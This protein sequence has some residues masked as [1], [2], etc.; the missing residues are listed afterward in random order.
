[1]SRN[2]DNRS[3]RTLYNKSYSNLS[4]RKLRYSTF[5]H[6]R[7]VRVNEIIEK[8]TSE[9]QERV[10]G[11]ELRGGK[12]AVFLPFT[13]AVFRCNRGAIRGRF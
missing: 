1:M 6:R 8:I 3:L 13:L 2:N 10:Q 12:Q 11:G 7:L 9:M 5:N 4:T